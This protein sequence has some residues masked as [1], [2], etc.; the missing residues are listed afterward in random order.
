MLDICTNCK[1]QFEKKISSLCIKCRKRINNQKYSNKYKNI[2]KVKKAEYYQDN[3]DKCDQY[4]KTEEYKI[5]KKISNKKY[6]ENNKNELKNKKS[7]YYQKNK[8]RLDIINKQWVKDN[9]E[10]RK[11]YIKKYDQKNRLTICG[12]INHRMSTA[13]RF[14][15]LNNKC[16]RSWEK[17]VGYAVEDLKGHI[18]SKFKCGMNWDEFLK[19]NIHID[20]IIPKSFFNYMDYNDLQFKICWSLSNLQ[21]MWAIDN[22]KKGNKILNKRS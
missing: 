1:I 14:S 8:K 2:I 11:M 15:L 18:E 6:R 21:P 13:I 22:L 17:L 12:N 10:K 3:K 7:E 4:A 9:P 19:G 20:H 16:G 5:K